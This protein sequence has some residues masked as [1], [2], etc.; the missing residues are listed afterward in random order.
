MDTE[1]A[2][3]PGESAESAYPQALPFAP[4]SRQN[5]R[6][7]DD[8]EA[9][10]TLH[11]PKVPIALGIAALPALGITLML[12]GYLIVG[13]SL[14]LIGSG[15]TVWLYWPFFATPSKYKER[16]K[17][18]AVGALLI[19]LGIFV[20]LY[21]T[22]VKPQ[23]PALGVAPLSTAPVRQSSSPSPSS[24]PEM[25]QL[26]ASPVAHSAAS[27][28]RQSAPS[29]QPAVNL[30]SS[31]QPTDYS[32][33]SD[34]IHIPMI[35]G[36]SVSAL[37]NYNTQFQ[38]QMD[39][40]E[41]ENDTF[42]VLL[43]N[44]GVGRGVIRRVQLVRIYYA[45]QSTNPLDA[46]ADNLTKAFANSSLVAQFEWEFGDRL[47]RIADT[48]LYYTV[49]DVSEEVVNDTV[50]HGPLIVGQN[51]VLDVKLAFPLDGVD[52]KKLNVQ[53]MAL[54]MTFVTSNG[55][56]VVRICP[57]VARAQVY[58]NGQHFGTS[59]APLA[60]QPVQILPIKNGSPICELSKY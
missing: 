26:M 47:W 5:R 43:S 18:M 1:I 39:G 11:G 38:R 27:Q 46:L 33:N 35:D 56:Q 36:P 41:I 12:A 14:C 29:G 55:S 21:V 58:R 19:W 54:R 42:K 3:P 37:V 53:V 23:T 50:Q 51:A 45:N 10:H 17:E 31:S 57:I 24:S 15:L 7:A 59:T 60:D 44:T 6:M 8:Q 20:P 22:V 2:P 52:R 25:R 28:T 49:R 13:W 34:K 48:E 32:V 40:E 4:D 30:H 16:R 9:N